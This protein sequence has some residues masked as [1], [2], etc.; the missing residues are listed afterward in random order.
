MYVLSLYNVGVLNKS[1]LVVVLIGRLMCGV[2]SVAP[3]RLRYVQELAH[4]KTPEEV[5]S[6]WIVDR[7]K[8]SRLILLLL[9]TAIAGYNTIVI[10]T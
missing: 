9:C 10:T 8:L 2:T 7:T 4:K 3:W 5:S 6:S 1:Q